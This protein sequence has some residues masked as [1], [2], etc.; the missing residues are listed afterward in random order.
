MNPPPSF[1]PPSSI[2]WL[3]LR[4]SSENQ[5]IES[6]ENALRAWCVE[7]HIYI[8]QTFRDEARTGATTAGRSGFTKLYDAVT[9]RNAVKPRA[10]LIWSWS[11]FAREVADAEFYKWG[12]RREGVHVWSV[13]DNVPEGEFAPIVESLTHYQDAKFL[14][15][16]KTDTTRGLHDL[17]A[18]GYSSGGF[19]PVGYKRGAPIVIGKKKNGETRYAHKWEIDA[20]TA[21]RV[22]LAWDMR[23]AGKSFWEIHRATKLMSN[24]RGYT[25]FFRRVTYAGAVK[26]GNTV[27]WDA[28]PAY[29]TRAEWESVQAKN[30]TRKAQ[31]C[32][33]ELHPMRRRQDS[34][35][36][37][38][39][40][41]KCGYCGWS[42]VGSLV[43]GVPYYRCD[44]RH[45]QG[46]ARTE[47]QQPALVAYHLHDFI[48]E[49]LQEKLL[50]FDELR[51]A[52]DEI[53]A[54]LSG[55]NASIR[56]RR[57]FLLS[58][59][60][61]LATVISNLIASLE[62]FGAVTEIAA[63]LVMRQDE[64]KR[65]HAELAEI[66]ASLRR[67]AL[68]I[69]DDALR[70]V[71]QNIKTAFHEGNPASVRDVLK[72]VTPR[73]DLY[74]DAVNFNYAPIAAIEML[75]PQPNTRIN[76]V[77]L[78][79]SR[80]YTS[81]RLKEIKVPFARLGKGHRRLMTITAT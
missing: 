21:P 73:V 57:A 61:R 80:L 43:R 52:R 1:L 20:D 17:A 78:T 77:P 2:V 67:G 14:E 56:D 45:R 70:F 5:S 79:G 41:L 54:A 44:W 36:V 16:L 64:Q 22:K 26:C 19:P 10:V 60:K 33:G 38:S 4:F 29:V 6:Q 75:L 23:L 65:N 81:Q 39:G 51:Q 58:E 15:R 59:Q 8:A 48:F 18:Q 30:R 11:R 24:A 3:Y 63:R 66:E 37:L 42:M 7:H 25:D 62:K 40:I 55:D 74:V 12:I 71:A 9:A 47:C 49:T 27:T 50:T 76:S 13:T 34:P 72:L 32:A 53:N 35:Y 68:E 46:Y 28:H 31:M 69:D